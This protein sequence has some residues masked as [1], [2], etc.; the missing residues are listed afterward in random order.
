MA[1]KPIVLV[2]L[3]IVAVTVYGFGIEPGRIAI[4][5]IDLTGTGIH[6]VLKGKTAVHLSDLHIF[7]IGAREDR[8]L[9]HIAA[10]KPDLIFLTGDYV[11]WNGDYAPALEFLSRLEAPLG[12]WAVLGD[13]DYSDSRKSCL[14]CHLPGSGELTNRHG[15]KFLRNA[16][17]DLE[18]D[19]GTVR[20]AGIDSDFD[21]AFTLPGTH[22]M[23][24]LDLPA[25]LLLHNPLQF[26]DLDPELEILVLAGDTHGGQIPLPGFVWKILGYQ[27]NAKYERGMFREGRKTMYV[28]RGVG[29]SHLPIRILRPPEL[30]VFSF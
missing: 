18:L 2:F 24:A 29:T 10:L 4:T 15:V 27:K 13:Y 12:V 14:F 22:G 6:P 3:F 23:A 19:G 20:I 11:E 28:S 1:S 17:Q 21:R 5:H 25:I 30:V 7:R 9:A 16:F 8:V 26:D